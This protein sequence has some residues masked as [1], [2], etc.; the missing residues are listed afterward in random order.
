MASVPFNLL[1]GE[2]LSARL[3]NS[4]KPLGQALHSRSTVSAD[5]WLAASRVPI[6]NN[7]T[8]FEHAAGLSLTES[9]R[10]VVDFS[11][12]YLL[13]ATPRM[14]LVEHS[15]ARPEDPWLRH[16]APPVFFSGDGVYLFVTSS[17]AEPQ[18]IDRALRQGMHPGSIAALA[19]LRGLR[20]PRTGEAVSARKLSSIASRISAVVLDAFDGEA[21]IVYKVSQHGPPF[22]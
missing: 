17:N 21:L 14:L 13:G 5:A 6:L 1:A 20:V 12:D 9:R 7:V 11:L 15:L 18:H 4:W 19:D 3:E 2:Y 16:E 8:D 22:L 10:A